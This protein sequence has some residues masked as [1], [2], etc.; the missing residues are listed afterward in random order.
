MRTATVRHEST[1][2][3]SLS[4]VWA[5]HADSKGLEAITPRVVGLTVEGVTRPPQT[6]EQGLPVGTRMVL[7]F[8]PLG[9]S[10]LRWV[11]RIVAR[12]YTDNMGRFVD[13]QIEG[14]FAFWEHT[15]EFYRD[16]DQTR[17]IDHIEYQLPLRLPNTLA[18]L[19]LKL[20]LMDRHRRTKGQLADR[21]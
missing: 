12:K 7:S 4:E 17:I 6:I 14:P 9:I 1:I 8:S 11:A 5:F 21:D 2:D 18:W 15:H 10:E 3:A 20:M 16:G 19:P 13:R